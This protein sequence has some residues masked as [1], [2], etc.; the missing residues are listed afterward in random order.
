MA[1]AMLEFAARPSDSLPASIASFAHPIHVDA[2]GL[3]TDFDADVDHAEPLRHE[4]VV[5]APNRR[6]SSSEN[7]AWDPASSLELSV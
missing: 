5:V 3:E 7:L 6:T 1:S 2:S 4:R